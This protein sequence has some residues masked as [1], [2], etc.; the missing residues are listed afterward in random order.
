M[1]NNN[2]ND[3]F[4]NNKNDNDYD[5]FHLDEYLNTDQLVQYDNQE[6]PQQQQHHSSLDYP[7]H[8]FRSLASETLRNFNFA[9]GKSL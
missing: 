2:S 6:S 4:S 1:D 7:A 3:I 8:H 9:N 5:I